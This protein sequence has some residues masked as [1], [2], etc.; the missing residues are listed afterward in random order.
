MPGTQKVEQVASQ[1]PGDPEAMQKLAGAEQQLGGALSRLFALSEAYPDL[2][3]NQNMMQLQEEL[4]STENRIAFA[5]QSFNDA[6]MTY[7]TARQT[8]PTNIIANS[9]R[10]EEA[11][12]FEIDRDEERETPQ[13]SFG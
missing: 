5:R 4:A 9:F 1:N 11:E 8:V 6:V 3:A 10:F 13:V 7:N 2:K 12:F